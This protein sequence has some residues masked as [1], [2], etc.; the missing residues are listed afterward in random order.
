MPAPTSPQPDSFASEK[1]RH[2]WQEAQ[3]IAFRAGKALVL[4][5]GST[6]L[7]SPDEETL[8]CSPQVQES[9]WWETLM[10]LNQD[11]P[12]LS[13]MWSK[14]RP[15]TKPGEMDQR[16]RR[17]PREAEHVLKQHPMVR[18]CAVLGVGEDC[19]AFVELT[20]GAEFDPAGLMSY[21]RK[22]IDRFKTPHTI[23]LVE[24]LPRRSDGKID[25]DELRAQK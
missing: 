2:F 18:E 14:G 22:H 6:W 11:F 10:A 3:D 7:I 4:R 21:A 19:I 20:P 12:A 1:E 23:R 5:D 17:F 9:V 8:V 13:R 25:Y 15:I 24:R 16:D